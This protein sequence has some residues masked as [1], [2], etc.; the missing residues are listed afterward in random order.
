MTTDMF[1]KDDIVT[2]PNQE[3]CYPFHNH[4]KLGG[5]QSRDFTEG[6][7]PVEYLVKKAARGIYRV[8]V[9]WRSGM[10]DELGVR[11][12]VRVFTNFGR[13]NQM[14]YLNVV[15]LQ[16]LKEIRDVATIQ[17]FN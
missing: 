4:T 14:E 17:I 8:Q 15:H 12:A 1:S 9:R 11:V 6:L 13:R 16:K 5:I 7:G 10:E 2:E 3:I